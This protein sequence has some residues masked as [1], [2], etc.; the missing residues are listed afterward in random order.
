MFK[1][2]QIN[3]GKVPKKLLIEDHRIFYY[4]RFHVDKFA[5]Y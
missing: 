5:D 1:I 2:L 4:N 3:Q